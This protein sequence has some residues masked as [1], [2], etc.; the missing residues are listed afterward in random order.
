MLNGQLYI[1]NQDAFTTWGIT[2]DTSSLSALMTPPPMKSN[3]VTSSRLQHGQTVS[4][5]NPRM[6]ARQLTLTIQLAAATEEAFFAQ[7]ASFCEELE[8]G[9]LNIRTSY[10][11]DIVYHMEYNS[12]QQFTQF[13]RDIAKFTLRLTENDPSNR[14]AEAEEEEEDNDNQ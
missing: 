5:L 13:Q 8:T 7:Y 12:C 10:Q 2:M 4:T 1:N 6:A 9:F 14:D 11:P 3:I